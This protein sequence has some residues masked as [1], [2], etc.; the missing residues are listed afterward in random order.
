MLECRDVK[1]SGFAAQHRV[2]CQ[3]FPKSERRDRR[4]GVE[5]FLETDKLALPQPILTAASSRVFP[6]AHRPATFL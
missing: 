2:T 4:N 1:F 5:R 3:F 6:L